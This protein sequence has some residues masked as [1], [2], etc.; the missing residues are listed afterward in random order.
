MLNNDIDIIDKDIPCVFVI[1]GGTGDLTKKK[2][3]PA[4]YKLFSDKKV[5]NNFAVVAVGRS[6][7]SHQEYRDQMIEDAIKYGEGEF[8]EKKWKE[9]ADSLYYSFFDMIKDEKGYS[10]LNL[11]LKSLDDLKKTKGNRIYY[12]AVGPDMFIPVLE[13]LN[14]NRMLENKN[15]WHRVI[16]EKPF[17]YSLDTARELQKSLLDLISEDKIFRIDHYLG[18]EMIQN[19]VAIRFSNSIFESLWNYK[20]ID[21]IQINSSE[22]IGI[23]GRA[24]Y[25]E[26]SGI[27]RDMLQSHILQMLSLICMEP[28]INLEANS[29][30]DEKVKVLKSLQLFDKESAKEN[31][32]LGQYYGDDKDNVLGY[33]EERNVDNSSM[34]PTYVA[35]KTGIKNYRWG[36]VPIYIRAGK[37]LSEKSSEIIIQFKKF[38]GIDI[39]D[40]YK[41]T[42]PDYLIIKIQPEEGINFQIN[43]KK[44]DDGNSVEKVDMSYCQ[45]CRYDINSP[46]AYERLILAAI[47]NNPSLFTRWDEV[48]SA[49]VFIDS[50]EKSISKVDLNFPNYKAGSVGPADAHILMSDWNKRI[51]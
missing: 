31:V 46:R 17:G 38:P 27:L 37:R 21:N 5:S 14:K 40:E 19:I 50:I 26:K 1:L 18:K 43:I 23:E 4:I 33:R 24:S 34:V 15:S 10:K 22:I 44:P 2:L 47:N 28:P 48:E 42:E 41:N 51:Y 16:I 20:Y 6:E 45:T 29:M 11:F 49:W 36:G 9:F 8:N 39:Y 32:V 30:R 3:I 12:L 25:Y 7:L 13:N 35:L